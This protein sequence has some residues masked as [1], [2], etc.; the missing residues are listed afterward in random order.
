MLRKS[1]GAMGVALLLA[2]CSTTVPGSPQA[3]PSA[4]PRPD[5]G[6]FATAPRTVSPMT[7]VQAAAAE[8]YRMV[9]IIPMPP[10]IDPAIRYD[11][12]FSVGKL[13]SIKGTF[14]AG[15]DTALQ[16]HE[17]GAYVS[18][19]AKNPGDSATKPGTSL[20]MGVMRMKDDAAATAAV[21]NPAFLGAEEKVVDT[22]PDKEPVSIPGYSGAKA[23][24][25]NWTSQ[26][27]VSTTALVASGRYVLLT[28][29]TAGVDAVKKFFD[30]QI[31]ALDGFQPTPVDKFSTLSKDRD[32]LLRYTLQSTSTRD[33]VLPARAAVVNQTDI[34][35][36]VKNFADAGV[37]LVARAS[38]QVYRAKDAAGARLLADRFLAEVKGFNA[39]SVESTVKGVPGGTCLTYPSYKGSKT[40]QTY[41]IAPVGR[42]LVELGDTQQ[43]RAEQA[44][45]ASYLIL[46]DAK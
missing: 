45:G 27:T 33:V 23:Y 10:D 36:S 1:L 31:K 20:I 25:K 6:S 8:G 37:D 38:N 39:G 41:C 15:A 14:G 13:T 5:T 40:T 3:D 2:G 32:G 4:M 7:D 29:T 35:G 43:N 46:K 9:E 11:G 17:V 16:D 18:A 12:R 44:L 30:A 21:A 28:Y 22:E 34:T 42:Y 19:T 26:N 24:S